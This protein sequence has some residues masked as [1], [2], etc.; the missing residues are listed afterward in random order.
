MREL[1]GAVERGGA[2]EQAEARI[3]D[4]DIGLDPAA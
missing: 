1:L 4:D 3:V 2:P